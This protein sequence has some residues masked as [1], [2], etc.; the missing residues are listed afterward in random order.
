MNTA[1]VTMLFAHPH[2]QARLEQ[3]SLSHSVKVLEFWIHHRCATFS[4]AQ[5]HSQLRKPVHWEAGA[6][7]HTATC[8][9]LC[10]QSIGGLVQIVG[11]T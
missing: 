3:S 5:R 10:T 9:A 7:A 11:L 1:T 6:Q 8:A 4:G 2:A